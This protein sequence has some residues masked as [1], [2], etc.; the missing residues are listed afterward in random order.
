[1]SDVWITSPYM[2]SSTNNFLQQQLEINKTPSGIGRFLILR[3]ERVSKLSMQES[4]P[5]GVMVQK[6]MSVECR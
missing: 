5:E 3:R 4:G 2:N 6:V 1:M